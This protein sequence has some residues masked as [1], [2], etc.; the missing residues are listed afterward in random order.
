MDKKIITLSPAE[1]DTVVGGIT[2]AAT[3]P[4]HSVTATGVHRPTT[5]AN[6]PSRYEA[7]L[8]AYP[9]PA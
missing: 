1:I 8:A 7:L 2:T 3:V 6:L 5:T 9:L 4:T